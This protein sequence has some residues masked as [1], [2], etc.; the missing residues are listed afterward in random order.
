M[1]TVGNIERPRSGLDGLEKGGRPLLH[2]DGLS[3]NSFDSPVTGHR[4]RSASE[5]DPGGDTGAAGTVHHIRNLGRDD[6]STRTY[7]NCGVW[8]P[9]LRSEWLETA[10]RSHRYG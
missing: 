2:R 3:A 6:D 8:L 10:R 5:L 9:V 7:C 4:G 1:P